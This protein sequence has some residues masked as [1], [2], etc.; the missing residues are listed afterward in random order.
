MIQLNTEFNREELEILIECAG[1]KLQILS[2]LEKPCFLLNY[3]GQFTFEECFGKTDNDIE[4]KQRYKSA[5][6]R[7]V[8]KF[9]QYYLIEDEDN[10]GEWY[11]GS[12]QNNGAIEGRSCCETLQFA[13]EIL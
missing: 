12:E 10:L 11:I 7:R 1:E 5:K 2:V 9:Y 4:K 13:F 6:P 8:L 3:Y